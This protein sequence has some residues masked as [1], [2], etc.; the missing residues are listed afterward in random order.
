MGPSVQ[1]CIGK[2]QWLLL[3]GDGK[4]T[5]QPLST[6]PT[7]VSNQ[8]VHEPCLA[9]ALWPQGSVALLPPGMFFLLRK[10]MSVSHGNED[11][12]ARWA[13]SLG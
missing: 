3:D 13:G 8:S 4:Q 2:V 6:V 12:F 7:C 9:M 1:R 5:A 10:E 11:V